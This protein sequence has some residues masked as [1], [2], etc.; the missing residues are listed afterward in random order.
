M[1]DIFSFR[2]GAILVENLTGTQVPLESLPGGHA[3]QTAPA[4]PDLGGDAEGS[5]F[6]LV[7]PGGFHR[8]HPGAEEIL[9]RTVCRYGDRNR[10]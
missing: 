1:G 6:L 8:T 3:E 7:N 10:F 5:P 9:F 2:Q 4:A